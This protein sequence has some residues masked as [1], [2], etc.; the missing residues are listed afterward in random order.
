ME[1]LVFDREEYL[2]TKGN[3]SVA[4]SSPVPLPAYGV[5]ALQP[6]E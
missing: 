6:N 3:T 2:A 1:A 4:V 5:V